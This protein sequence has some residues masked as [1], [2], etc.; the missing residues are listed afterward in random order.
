MHLSEKFTLNNGQKIPAI[1]LGTFQGDSGNAGVKDAVKLAF[2]LGYRH[3][4]T[5]SV[6]GNEK[7]IG[8]AIKECG[9][10]RQE[11]YV[12]SKLAQ[13]WHE[14]GDVE[15]AIDSTLRDL[16]LNYVDLYLM[17]FPHAYKP[18]KDNSTI[19][20][21]SG[22]GKPVIDYE[23]SRNYPETWKAMERLVDLG[24]A[25]SIGLA[26]FNILKTKRILETARIV[27]AINQ[28]ELHPYLPQHALFEF[29]SRNGILLMAHQPLGGRPAGVVRGHP[30]HPF[31]TEDPK[32]KD[33]ATLAGMT[34]AQI[35]LSW[36]VQRGIAVI[37]KSV[38]EKHM[39][40]NFELKRLSEVEFDAVDG[41]ADTRGP[42]RFLDPSRHLGFNIFDEQH[43]QPPRKKSFVSGLLSRATTEV[44]IQ[45]DF[46]TLEIS[47][48]KKGALGLTTLHE[49]SLPTRPV[50]DIVFIHGLGGGS[51][52]TWSFSNE[53]YHFW[54]QAWLPEE[55]DLSD[56]RIH[57]FGYNA[58]WT[59]RRQS[60]LRIYDFAQSL[61]SELKNNPSVR[62][63]STRIILVGHSM[64]GCVAKK[65]YILARQDQ[66]CRDLAS[67]MHSIFFLGT[68]H[69][70]SD[71][72]SILENML[73]VT[74]G[75]KPFVTDLTPN[76]SAMEQINDEF[77]H[78]AP[79]L[80]LWS[81]Y[82]TL[83]ISAGMV[84]RIIVERSS[85]TL[86][87]H[88]EEIAAMNAD[89]R[90]VCKF[91]SPADPNYK[92]LRN[93][94][95]TAVDLIRSAALEPSLPFTGLH[96]VPAKRPSPPQ[97]DIDASL[98]IKSFLS[99]DDSMESYLA[100]LQDLREPGSCLWFTEKPSFTSWHAGGEHRILWL[101]GSP[102]TGKSI[103]AS[104]VIDHLQFSSGCCSYFLYGHT[105][106]ARSTLSDAFRALAFQ[107]A[108]QDDVIRDAI[109]Q[110]NEHDPVL[111]KTDE[112]L[113]WRKL[114]VGSI[115][116][117][118]SFAQHFW[119]I[120]GLDECVNSNT[121]FTKRLLAT[122]PPGLRIFATSRRLDAIERG[123][124]ALG[125]LVSVHELTDLDT[126]ADMRLFLAT[127]L[128]ELDRLD[129]DLE[130]DAMCDKILKKSSGSFLW[131][132][133]VLQE[134]ENAWTQEAMESVLNEVPVRLQDLYSRM[135]F[136]IE[137]DRH[138]TSLAKSILTWVVL[139]PR[140]LALEELRAAVQL[141]L[142]QKLQNISKAIPNLCGQLVL[143]DRDDKVRMI[144]E[145]AREFLLSD[146][147]CSK[148]SVHR[149]SHARLGSLLLRYLSGDVLKSRPRRPHNTAR[150][151]GF[152][153]PA[154]AAL[155]PPELP[156]LDYACRYFSEH[157]YRCTS[158]DYELAE[159]L[160]TFLKGNN[161][162]SWVEHIA[163]SQDLN[164]ITRTAINLRRY[165]S[166]R[167]KYVPPTD[168]SIH[169]IDSWVT[170][171]I[172]VAAKFRP[173]LLACPSS[174]HYLIP[175]LCPSDSVIARTYA[176]DPRPAAL[177]VEGLPRGIWDDCLIRI[178]FE[179]GQTTAVTYGDSL[180]AVGLSTGQISIY[181]AGSVQLSLRVTH[182]ERVKLLELSRNDQFLLSCGN[183]QLN[184]WNPK[185]GDQLLVV[186]LESLPLAFIFLS[187]DELLGAFQSGE[188]RKWN[189]ETYEHDS[190]SWK[191]DADELASCSQFSVPDQ[192]PNRAAFISTSEVVMLALGYRKHP[193]IL[194]NALEL[195]LQG[196]CTTH[197]NNGIDDMVFN[198]NPEI[199]ALVVSYVD[200]RLCVFDY[201]STAATS[202]LSDRFAH[203]LA[204]SPDGR[205]LVAGSSHGGIEVFK[206]D[207]DSYGSVG[208]V[209]IYRL[210][211][212]DDTIRGVSFACDGL[213]FVD[214]HAQQCRVWAPAALV[215]MSNELESTSDAVILP[216]IAGGMMESSEEHEITSNITASEDGRYVVAGKRGGDVVL[217]STTKGDEV[218]V[219]FRHAK[220]VCVVAI[221]LG[222]AGNMVASADD[223][224]RV[225]VAELAVPLPNHA[226]AAQL[227]DQKL[228]AARIAFQRRFHGAVQ[229]LLVNAAADRLVVSGRW[230]DELWELPSG[231]VLAS[232]KSDTGSFRSVFQHPRNS[233]WL[234]SMDGGTANILAWADFEEQS[235]GQGAR[236]ERPVAP[237][238]DRYLD[239]TAASAVSHSSGAE[240]VVEFVRPTP[241]Q[242]GSLSI[243]PVAA[244]DLPPGS[245]FPMTDP[246]LETITPTILSIIGFAS[247]SMLV[248]LD[249]NLWVC[250]LELQHFTKA[251]RPSS[252]RPT[253][254]S[255]PTS[256]A[257]P[258]TPPKPS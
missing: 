50:A 16:Q 172:R 118:P 36:A 5:A 241:S 108:M 2:K 107:M 95:L 165:L 162:L 225:L 58:D 48:D 173:Q 229:R 60:V 171:L 106:T 248:F 98:R 73:V 157:L 129:S 247:P 59:G 137:E 9:I 243:W 196:Q 114:F 216:S 27:P 140:P 28:V 201:T 102:A 257:W 141:D 258:S 19:R 160:C 85:A 63:D 49:P 64:G 168:P 134:F 79:D 164:D 183:K 210:A 132:R 29:S 42:R 153:R 33:I 152:A 224:G 87:Y 181:D 6:Y 80:R 240:Y 178:D 74:W 109:L 197:A 81:F 61:I 228:A 125:P 90:Q 57:S 70:G 187:S 250:T 199:P 101:T 22:N 217:F 89:H 191:F 34:P 111:D 136:S 128:R 120:D 227:P 122:T 147:L 252:A 151:R 8:D 204:C 215:R 222:E 94:L 139:A 233:A 184:L 12:T 117:L 30:D 7:E 200:G 38:Q 124:A 11:I 97:T 37:P 119:V 212:E 198:P 195:Q 14:P 253:L 130:C 251:H 99:I 230:V 189:L 68:P 234:V 180:F 13:T 221:A 231:D 249:I 96:D 25:R 115:F 103:I 69:R 167:A 26:N 159:D 207:Q 218:G 145:T 15:K 39:R 41:L 186:P 144:H 209:P 93:S 24:K 155:R 77:R 203:S 239:K 174:I 150:P 52:K 133:L 154:T 238:P 161:V 78:V 156:L 246:A 232:R 55:P 242:L 43:D 40:Q 208:L 158:E 45:G 84:N 135:L 188:L 92:M 219:L 256:S 214:V 56:V 23:M 72:A 163:K 54:P 71:M 236:L 66:T 131:V 112:A 169:L 113:V 17:H 146:S 32:I 237:A 62:R 190:I 255:S 53:P 126:L 121:L 176:K 175:P 254:H 127:K 31:P 47:L 226:A 213:R 21:S 91:A 35:C 138:K 235:S 4:D 105:T 51:R 244:F 245:A 192:P 10:P 206:F 123:L 182:P 3:I 20:H 149:R 177:I 179:H 44:D 18:G 1:G 100:T 194:W 104:H 148:L 185:T 211:A 65:A 116:K 223:S 88:N 86:G 46:S 166:R 83:P 110:L 75:R 142:N 67:R 193:V 82:E 202:T 76:S 143:I 220:G 170:D 205:S